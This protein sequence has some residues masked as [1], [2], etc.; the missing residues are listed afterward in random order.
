MLISSGRIALMLVLFILFVI[1]LYKQIQIRSLHELLLFSI[2]L[3][4]LGIALRLISLQQDV[5]FYFISFVCIVLGGLT[6]LI[7]FFFKKAH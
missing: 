7:S 3:L 2:S 4:L 5:A 6:A 1:L